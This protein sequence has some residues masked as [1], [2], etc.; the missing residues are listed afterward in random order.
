MKQSNEPPGMRAEAAWS[1]D[2]DGRLAGR[3]NIL[4]VEDN[5]GDARLIVEALKDVPEIDAEITA[6]ARISEAERLLQAP[7]AFTLILLDLHL[8]DCEGIECLVRTRNA[9]PDLPVVVLT[10]Q[11]DDEQARRYIELGAQDYLIKGETD[12]DILVRTLRYALSR[13]SIVH[14]LRQQNRGT[15]GGAYRAHHA[16]RRAHR[17]THPP[18]PRPSCAER[19]QP[20]GDAC[21]I[22]TAAAPGGVSRHHRDRRLRAGVGGHSAAG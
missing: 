21:R 19:R 18:Q 2:I 4:L 20:R 9:A 7:H 12:R 14:H 15:G 8:D 11:Q 6:T 13:A 16:R 5:P 22:G 10:G 17:G 3:L 1:A